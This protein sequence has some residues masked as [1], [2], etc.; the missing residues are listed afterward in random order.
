LLRHGRR[1]LRDVQRP[2]G[3]RHLAGRPRR[4]A[5]SASA[6]GPRLPVPVPALLTPLAR[7]VPEGTELLDE[8]IRD[9]DLRPVVPLA[10]RD[11]LSPQGLDPD[12][13]AWIMAGSL[14]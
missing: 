13:A 14:P 10:E 4:L 6:G 9:P 2:G 7:S 8:L 3:D 5:G 12:E 1:A 11:N